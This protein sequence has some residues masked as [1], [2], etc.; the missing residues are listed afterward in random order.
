MRIRLGLAV[1]F[2]VFVVAFS[3][4][5]KKPTT[6][7]EFTFFK[8]KVTS[9]GQ[10]VENAL[11]QLIWGRGTNCTC[12]P[13]DIIECAFLDS[14][15]TLQPTNKAGEYSME[16]SWDALGF[17]F[18]QGSPC[19]M[20][21]IIEIAPEPQFNIVVSDTFALPVQSRGTTQVHDFQI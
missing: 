5:T 19:Q 13:G 6:F 17:L 15:F 10:P 14:L 8:G 3:C 12:K 9:G 16:I 2:L 7:N 4:T 1:L 21:Y 18:D 20:G 11:V